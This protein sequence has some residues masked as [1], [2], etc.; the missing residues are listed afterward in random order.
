[1]SGGTL[2]PHLQHLRIEADISKTVC[3]RRHSVGSAL[4]TMYRNNDYRGLV[5]TESPLLGPL[6]FDNKTS[7]ARDH[8]ANER[9]KLD[10]SP[11]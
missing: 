6:L 10:I 8:C 9:S 11:G 1:M 4:L 7:D 5:F 3:F 2:E